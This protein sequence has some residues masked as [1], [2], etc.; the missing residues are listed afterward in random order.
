M[1][2]RVWIT[3]EPL[4]TPTHCEQVKDDHRAATVECRTS[5]DRV[6][7]LSQTEGHSRE[8]NPGALCL[9]WAQS[10]H[11]T[12]VPH[13]CSWAPTVG[14]VVMRACGLRLRCT[15][16]FSVLASLQDLLYSAMNPL[17]PSAP[18]SN[19]REAVKYGV[20]AGTA[21]GVLVYALANVASSS[22]TTLAAAQAMGQV[23]AAQSVAAARPVFSPI[24]RSGRAA[25]I[26]APVEVDSYGTYN[27]QDAQTVVSAA[28]AAQQSLVCPLRRLCFPALSH[29]R[30]MP[31]MVSVTLLFHC[32]R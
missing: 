30:S 27:V 19:Q 7:G 11:V 12:I 18:G 2:K 31:R 9:C 8:C 25:A 6:M 10:Y 5:V 26:P 3:V 29:R 17:L 32:C 24:V 20:L 22:T 1:G 16:H 13:V 28:P 23:Q 4:P 21:M 14:L 15:F